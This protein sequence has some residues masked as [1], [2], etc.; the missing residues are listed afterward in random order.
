[1]ARKLTVSL[2][3]N[4][5]RYAA[6]LKTA[7]RM[8]KRFNA[9]MEKVLEGVDIDVD[10]V[11]FQQDL[12]MLEQQYERFEKDV[13]SDEV[14]IRTGPGFGK[15]ANFGIV[16]TGVVMGIR[17]IGMTAQKAMKPFVKFQRGLSRIN[18]I[19]NVSEARLGTLG[20]GLEEVGADIGTPMNELQKGMY[21]ALSR[22]IEMG[23]ALDFV[24]QNAKAAE[25][26]TTDLRSTI[27]STTTVLNAFNM[28]GDKTENILD[29]MFA[30]VEKG[31]TSFEEL[32]KHISDVA[33]IA[34]SAGVDFKEVGTA[35]ATIT[36][37]GTPTA[38]AT[39][40]IKRA[41][42]SLNDV[43][44]E[45]WSQ[46]MG[47]QEAMAKVV[48]KA[49]KSDKS[50]KELVGRVQG[51]QGVLQLTGDSARIYEDAQGRIQDATGATQSAYMN[52]ANDL[53]HDIDRVNSIIKNQARE[54]GEAFE[55]AVQGISEMI[56]K[57]SESDM[58]TA[59][60]QLKEMGIAA[61]KLQGLQ[62]AVNIENA[63]E[64]MEETS[65]GIA[66]TVHR[67]WL[68]LG[69]ARNRLVE[70]R[71][72]DSSEGIQ[73][74]AQRVKVGS[75]NA[76]ELKNEIQSTIG[77]NRDLLLGRQSLTD[78]QQ[79]QVNKARDKIAALSKLLKLVKQRN[80][81]QDKLT[82]NQEEQVEYFQDTHVPLQASKDT[83]EDMVV[84][85]EEAQFNTE[86]WKE[87]ADLAVYSQTELKNVSAQ[88]VTEMDK[89]K[90]KQDIP[91]QLSRNFKQLNSIIG[92]IASNMQRTFS[93]ALTEMAD[94][95]HLTF[96]SITQSFTN[97]LKQMVVEMTSRAA[98][99]GL[100]S[101]F[102]P[103]GAWG[104]NKLSA[105]SALLGKGAAA[106][107]KGPLSY[108][109]GGS[110][111]S[112]GIAPGGKISVFGENGPEIGIPKQDTQVIDS[113]TLRNALTRDER[114]ININ[115]N[116][117]LEGDIDHK[118]IHLSSVLGKGDSY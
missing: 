96:E 64:K 7:L 88:V 41:I 29:T 26:G 45:G 116:G 81:A 50:L 77:A 39:T 4:L 91:L 92:S 90:L 60:R 78:K 74:L 97:M 5:D 18:T 59:V 1:M 69:E 3:L 112:G 32:S 109:F 28:E 101:L 22:G 40:Q 47:L 8:G 113:E 103:G 106:K 114:D 82:Q 66:N 84:P 27:R 38:K 12:E 2:E 30:T 14:N 20:E 94:Q 73:N 72:I 57:L 71:D 89:I 35:I 67:T 70:L 43:L 21:Q 52:M 110:F 79:K 54:V 10:K 104:A 80:A 87:A 24:K 68:D 6:G 34:A 61:E 117:K 99:F 15:L 108:I 17:Q 25:G 105:A 115:I 37:Q 46:T 33:P 9:N 83:L 13:E 23:N 86:R 19:A 49:D 42:L 53:Q 56:I 58:E 62:Y 95:G 118:T 93:N 75:L 11:G 44:G 48:E 102:S 36:K 111:A 51:Y 16:A 55:P 98:I 65:K 63:M 76:K 100:L 31:G 85:I 107:G